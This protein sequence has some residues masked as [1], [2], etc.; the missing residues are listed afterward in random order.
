MMAEP[1]DIETPGDDLL[2]MA[3]VVIANA[4]DWDDSPQGSWRAAAERWRD[5]YFA[6][7]GIV[8]RDT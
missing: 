7:L 6:T 2:E 1:Q 3:W 5:A 4:S 8:K